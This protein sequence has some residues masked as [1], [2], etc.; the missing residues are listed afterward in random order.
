MSVHF[1]QRSCCHK[2]P[3]CD[4]ELTSNESNRPHDSSCEAPAQNALP[5]TTQ[6]N[7]EDCCVKNSTPTQAR[8]YTDSDHSSK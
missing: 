1:P 2:D 8:D 5:E 4:T 6:P 3:V 7:K